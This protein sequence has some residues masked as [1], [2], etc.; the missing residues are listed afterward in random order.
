M[1]PLHLD[2]VR[3]TLG[4]LALFGM[5]AA[6][7]TILAP[8]LPS[9][10]WAITLV[11]ATWPILLHVQAA[12]GGRRGLAVLTMT[13]LLLAIVVAPFGAAVSTILHNSDQ[14]VTIATA[15]TSAQI[16]EAPDWVGNLPLIGD[17]AS[18]TWNSLASDGATA[19][20]AELKPYVGR[21]TQSF[22][23]IAGSLGTVFVQLLLTIAVAV[24]LYANGE[25]AARAALRFGHRIAGDRG[26]QSVVLA[27]QAIRGVAL[28]VVVTALAQSLLGGI[29]LLVSG[30]PF[31][32]ILTAVMLM[33]CI[34][35]VGPML[36]LLPAVGWL[37]FNGGTT[38]AVILLVWSVLVISL[39]NVLRPILIRKGAN[40][41][42][43]LIL[44]G[45]LGGL[46]S[47]GLIGLFVGPAM[48]AVAYTLLNAWLAEDGPLQGF[49]Q[50]PEA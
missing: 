50:T 24:I 15:V 17:V 27:G 2:L 16:P 33:M 20:L 26:Q 38:W 49:E 6:T 9:T 35:Q 11:I 46:L 39:D 23:G 18:S 42:L 22:V 4:V 21:I 14:I 48:L 43:L 28:G 34:V 13:L 1:K 41:P 37:F 31:A 5:I 8:F 32:G 36:V 30:V 44:V 19:L 29:G 47:F 7:F 3:I 40:L 10:V 12:L 45:V 25:L